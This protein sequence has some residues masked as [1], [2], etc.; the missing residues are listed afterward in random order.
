M[1]YNYVQFPISGA[2]Q[3]PTEQEFND[4]EGAFWEVLEKYRPHKIIVWGQRLYN[5]LPQKG[6]Q[7]PDIIDSDGKNIETWAYILQDGTKVQLLP[8][9]HPSAAFSPEYWHDVIMKFLRQI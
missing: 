9:T 7:L 6:Y 8:I 2:R 4:S 3:A 5:H 1:F